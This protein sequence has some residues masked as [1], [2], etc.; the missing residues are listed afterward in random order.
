MAEDDQ[1]R[2]LRHGRDPRHLAVR[3]EGLA[4]GGSRPLCRAARSRP[5]GGQK[6]GLRRVHVRGDPGPALVRPLPLARPLRP[7]H[8]PRRP[9]QHVQGRRGAL[10]RD[11]GGPG[12]PREEVRTGRRL[13]RRHRVR[14]VRAGEPAPPLPRDPIRHL[15]VQEGEGLPRDLLRPLP[16]PRRKTRRGDS[17]R[18]PPL[19]RLRGPQGGGAIR[20]L[21]RPGPDGVGARR[22][23]RPPGGGGAGDGDVIFRLKVG[24]DGWRSE[25]HI[26]G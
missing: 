8:P 6:A 2:I 16:L 26:K 13:Q 18:R 10:P 5:G 4:G 19:L 20:A 22:R 1:D 17:H 9:P 3:G 11:R 12:P 21:P 24:T 23:P 25:N 15:Q 14:G 7:G